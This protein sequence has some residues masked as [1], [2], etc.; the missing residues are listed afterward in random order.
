MIPIAPLQNCESR[1]IKPALTDIREKVSALPTISNQFHLPFPFLFT[2]SGL[3]K[4]ENS[5]K[6][7]GV[8]GATDLCFTLG[9]TLWQY[10]LW[11]FQ[12]QG[13]KFCLRIKWVFFSENWRKFSVLLM[14]NNNSIKIKPWFQFEVFLSSGKMKIIDF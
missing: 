13:T 1:V 10:R 3:M 12:M 6:I 4:L 11:S 9:F 8:C 7:F 5:I 14:K 2:R